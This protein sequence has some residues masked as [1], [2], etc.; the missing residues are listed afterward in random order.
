VLGSLN[1]LTPGVPL[2]ALAAALIFV[3][4]F[5]RLGAPTFWD[6]DE[7]HYAQT[8]REMMTSGDW[9]A[10]YFNEEPFFDKPVLFHQL[11]GA[12]MLVFGPTEFAARLVPALASLVLIIITVWFGTRTVSLDVGITAGLLL[13]ASPGVFAL[14]RYAILDTLFSAA[15]FGGA[16]LIAV[17]VLRDA[18]ALQWWG[19]IAV[20]LG[21]LIKGP[22]AFVLC[23]LTVVVASMLS[24]DARHR[25]LA[26]H[27]LLGLLLAIGIALPWFA[28]MVVRFRE[29]FVNVYFVDENIRLFA[30]R[31]FAN[32]PRPWFYFQIL[33]AGLL[34]WSGL[35]AGR[36]V[37]DVRA[38]L[39]HEAVDTLE[40]LLWSWTA[41]IVGFFTLSTFK[42]DHY[43]FPAAPA[44]CLLCARAWSD[45]RADPLDA[46]RAGA[47]AGL[48]LVGP[49]LVV[50]GVGCGYFVVARL[51]LP[52]VAVVVPIAV[53]LAGA[54]LTA[55]INIQGRAGRKPPRYPWIALVALLVTYTG[56]IAFVLPALEARKVVPDIARWVAAHA[57]DEVRI[58]SYRLNRWNPAYRFYVN[59]HVA[60]IDDPREAEEFFRS[61]RPF[62]CA[63]RR[64]AFHEFVAQ[65]IPLT[66]VY[67]REGMWATSGRVLWRRRIAPEQFVVVSKRK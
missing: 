37:D 12:A 27:W 20:G 59:R 25:L 41:A 52:R 46:R 40:I 18:G 15:V 29:A 54:L 13:T 21:V 19:Y 67:Q 62:Y 5:W 38:A 14:S 9:W 33:A 57:G 44:L 7:A 66:V 43:V 3:V 36:L 2:A 53:A 56:I 60:L 64:A 65:G 16:A 42:L 39:R 32:Q 26:L 1:R 34:P 4:L 31:R 35:V 47:R 10:P 61:S 58:A 24:A 55:T 48:H 22:V 49:L 51:E 50:L 30:G 23:G 45:V 17:A 11:Q 6:P 28:Y 8:A 63:M